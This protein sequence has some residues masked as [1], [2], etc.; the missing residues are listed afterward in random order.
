MRCTTAP[1]QPC[2]QPPPGYTAPSVPP[3]HSVTPLHKAADL[4]T[5]AERPG[6]AVPDLLA[7][8]AGPS[9]LRGEARAPTWVC[10]CALGYVTGGGLRWCCLSSRNHHSNGMACITELASGY[11]GYNWNACCCARARQPAATRCSSKTASCTTFTTTSAQP[12]PGLDIRTPAEREARIALRVRT[13]RHTRPAARSW[14]ARSVAA[15]PR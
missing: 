12:A 7:R 6:A 4:E 15:L 1:A 2:K 9:H 14:R 10:T 3:H 13:H 8:F 11:P 5:A